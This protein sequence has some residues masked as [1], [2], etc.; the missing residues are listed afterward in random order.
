M[1]LASVCDGRPLIG[2][3]FP[4]TPCTPAC[5]RACT[6]ERPP[7]S[8]PV[9]VR[10]SAPIPPLP[11]ASPNLAE[12]AEFVNEK[13][14]VSSCDIGGRQSGR[15]GSNS[16]HSA[17]EAIDRSV[18]AL[19]PS[20]I[21][22]VLNRFLVRVRIGYAPTPTEY[23]S[24]YHKF[25]TRF[26]KMSMIHKPTAPPVM[27]MQKPKN[28]PTKFQPMRGSGR[29][30]LGLSGSRMFT[31]SPSFA[32]RPRPIAPHARSQRECR[33]TCDCP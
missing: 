17:W 13:P 10:P 20:G 27:M 22:A 33:R 7:R 2:S 14:P 4:A 18:S 26:H 9:I 29:V 19:F 12:S 15:G 31:A 30:V 25:A 11:P 28:A 23:D 24:G 32:G 6:S 5:T 3:L 8:F 16:R 1:R 21:G